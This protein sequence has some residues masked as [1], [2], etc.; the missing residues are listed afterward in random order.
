MDQNLSL[1][2]RKKYE[3]LLRNLQDLK[4]ERD[5]NRLKNHLPIP[6][7]WQEKFDKSQATGRFMCVGN[8]SGKTHLLCAEVARYA[9]GEHPH[10]IIRTPNVGVLVSAQGFQEGIVKNVLP[11]MESAVG[12]QDIRAI[13]R[14]S[15]GIPTSILWRS[16]SLTYLMSAE[17]DDKAFEGIT[18]DYFGIDEPLRRAIYVALSRGLM[19][20]NGHWWWAA[21]LL[22][23]PWIFE[24]IYI[25]CQ[26][27]KLKSVELFTGTTDDNTTLSEEGKREDFSIL[28]EDEIKI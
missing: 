24:E 17:Q 27:G 16:G 3:L 20:S 8:Q 21:T 22:D 6:G 11:K 1:E 19:K 13:R 15:Q 26:E 23:E 7:T 25:P 5:R 9:L 28:S 18:L 12:S 2:D 14:N 10:K 4:E